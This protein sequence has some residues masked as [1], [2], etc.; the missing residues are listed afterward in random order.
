[1]NA[2]ALGLETLPI[3]YLVLQSCPPLN[4]TQTYEKYERMDWQGLYKRWEDSAEN[5]I[6]MTSV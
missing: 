1:M 4:R 3:T 6:R 2:I 5:W